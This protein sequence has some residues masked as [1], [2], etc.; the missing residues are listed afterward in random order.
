MSPKLIHWFRNSSFLCKNPLRQIGRDSLRMQPLQRWVPQG[1]VIG[2][3]LYVIFT[4]EMTEVVKKPKC[5][6]QNHQDRT[7]IFGTQCRECGTL[8]LYADD[9]TYVVGNKSRGQNQTSQRRNL[10]QMECY[11]NDNQLAIN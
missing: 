8:T 11:L 5:A 2:P 1:S 10:D 7:T 4:N 6:E 3:L 9:S